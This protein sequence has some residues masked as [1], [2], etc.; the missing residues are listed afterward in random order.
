MTTRGGGSLKHFQDTLL[1]QPQL[2]NLGIMKSPGTGSVIFSMYCPIFEGQH[3]TDYVGAGV[4]ASRPMDSL[5]NLSIKGLPDSEYVFLNVNT[6]VYLYHQEEALLNTETSDAGYREILRRIQADGSV[7]AGNYS[8]EDQQGVQQLV[9]YKYLKDRNWVFM[10]RD[11]AA[12][13]YGAV[14]AVR[15]VVGAL[16]AVMAAIILVTLLILRR[17][18]RTLNSLIRRFH[19]T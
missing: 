18:G 10:V 14:T 3:C 13:V 19:S 6:G 12:E 8:C 4:Y 2:T 16:C 17:E 1:S 5:L 11:S 9:V 7:Q 15:V